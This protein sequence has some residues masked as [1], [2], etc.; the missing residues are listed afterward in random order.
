M[1]YAIHFKA[2]PASKTAR[3]A[4]RAALRRYA[5]LVICPPDDLPAGPL[6]AQ[7][8]HAAACTITAALTMRAPADYNRL[9]IAHDL[10]EIAKSAPAGRKS[11]IDAMM[12]D[13]LLMDVYQGLGNLEKAARA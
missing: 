6:E 10:A 12:A 7:R 5:D 1:A 8:L 4:F 13:R 3:Q 9:A 2:Y 11:C